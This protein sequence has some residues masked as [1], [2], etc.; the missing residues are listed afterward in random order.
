M[1]AIIIW[2][3]QEINKFKREMD[4]LVDRLWDEFP[5]PFYRRA[6]RDIPSI[7]LTET[8]DNLIV[9]VEVPGINPEDLDIS[10]TENV[11]TIKGEMKEDTADEGG[12]SHWAERRYGSFSRTL[13]LPCRIKTEEVEA[14]YRKGI[15][16]IVMPKC[17]QD[18][19]REVKVKIR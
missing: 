4:R 16:T 3:K 1:Q 9:T 8:R 2:K 14:E 10:M 15:L 12:D 7:D 6:T 19:S 11:L 18:R 17:E 13:E 5:T